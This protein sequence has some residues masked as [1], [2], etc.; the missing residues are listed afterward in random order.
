MNW[1]NESRETVSVGA[2]EAKTHLSA[3]LD[4]VSQGQEVVITRRGQ[5]VARLIPARQAK[6]SETESVIAELR[7]RRAGLTLGGLNWKD[8]RDEGRR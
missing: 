8:L 5:P 4:K 7:R 1:L 2:F 6:R 3:L